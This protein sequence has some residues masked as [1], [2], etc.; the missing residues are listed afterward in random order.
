MLRT[1]IKIIATGAYLPKRKVSSTELDLKMG[2]P[3]GTVEQKTG[4]KERYYITDESASQMAA[5]AIREALEQAGLA[6]D[7]MDVLVAACGTYEQWI[8]CN[9]SLI[10]KAMGG[11][12]KGMPCFDVNS[13]CL[14]FV[15]AFDTLSYLLAAGRYK[16]AIIV[17]SD[18]ASVGLNYEHL[19]SSALFGDGAVAYIVEAD[20][21]GQSGVV[22]SRF[23]TYSE[24]AH[25]TE[26]RGGSRYHP[27]DPKTK[28]EDFL[29]SMDGKGIFKLASQTLPPFCYA[30]FEEAQCWVNDFDLI[31]PHQASVTA[32]RLM[33]KKMEVPS[34]KYY[35]N[36]ERYGNMIAAS[37]PFAF[38]CAL[39]EQRVKR[40]DTVLL[41]GT[42]AGFTLG[43]VI[44]VY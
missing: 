29:F 6:F 42:S 14:S 33:Q 22:A 32:V 26:I 23:E 40:G 7:D 5:S 43:A 38:H 28:P 10:Q 18:V 31:V 35:V 44:F 8:P 3:E 34:S 16:R 2:L 15:T 4:V 41:C 1:G 12:A 30:L 37:I 36:I 17:S 9:A 27:N 24:G 19:E 20:P 21:S 11:S 13:T 39:Q 25:L